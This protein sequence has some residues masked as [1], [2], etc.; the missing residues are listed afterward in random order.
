MVLLSPRHTLILYCD[1]LCSSS[2]SH[3]RHLV[4]IPRAQMHITVSLKKARKFPI[5]LVVCLHKSL[6]LT[7]KLIPPV[8]RLQPT[9]SKELLGRRH[10]G[11]SISSAQWKSPLPVI[12]FED[13]RP[14]T[15]SP[16]V[17]VNSGLISHATLCLALLSR[18]A[19]PSQCLLGRIQSKNDQDKVN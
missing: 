12:V 11:S 8:C 7:N 16:V 13:F 4:T 6:C 10:S 9:N 17:S 5:I 14:P 1:L 19:L 18:A 3:A 15:I 2:K